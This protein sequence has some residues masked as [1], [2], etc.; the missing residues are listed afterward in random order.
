[1]QKFDAF[2]TEIGNECGG[3]MEKFIDAF[4]SFLL[5]R[6][7]FFYESDPGD[8]MGFPPGV[9]ESMLASAFKR[10]QDE[11]YKKH[12]KKSLEEYKKKLAAYEESQKTKEKSEAEPVLPAKPIPEPKSA[13]ER[14]GK[15]QP[16]PISQPTG[17]G[18]IPQS[19]KAPAP[20]DIR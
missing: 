2:F 18:P 6:T 19:T 4:M 9:A 3:S 16:A 1:M 20:S 13:V 17:S 5:R 8:S 10:H 7:D 11:H 12:P 15:P 14:T